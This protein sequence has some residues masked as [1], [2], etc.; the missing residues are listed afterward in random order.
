MVV[1]FAGVMLLLWLLARLWKDGEDAA[2]ASKAMPAIELELPEEAPAGELSS[3]E[4]QVE[5]E[6]PTGEVEAGTETTTAETTASDDLKRIEGIGPKIA[7]VLQEAGIT[8][9][10]QL[11]DTEVALLEEIL[12]EADPRLLR[13]SD[14]SSWPE[15]AALAAGGEWDVLEALQATLER[16]RRVG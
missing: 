6:E 12:E 13:L 15:Q 10:S 2:E 16:G 9:F 5:D 8:T 7:S 14:P 1:A 11:A 4:R 3:A